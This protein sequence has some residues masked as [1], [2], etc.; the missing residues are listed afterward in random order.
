[1]E[2]KDMLGILYVMYFT[3]LN[4]GEEEGGGKEERLGDEALGFTNRIDLFEKL[5]VFFFVFFLVVRMLL[6]FFFLCEI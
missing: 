3:N 5:K 2:E 4:V 1:M 6:E